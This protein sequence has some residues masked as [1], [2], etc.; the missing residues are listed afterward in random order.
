[1]ALDQALEALSLGGRGHIDQLALGEDVALELLAD[2]QAVVAPDL[3]DV[4]VGIGAGLL[5]LAQQRLGDLPL[6]DR[7]K[8]QPDRRV[9][10]L[11]DGP[12]PEDAAGPHLEHGHGRDGA[13]GVEDL[14]HAELAGEESFRHG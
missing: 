9:A 8:G 11:L 2:L 6:G 13:V 14:R 3:G 4:P 1:M 12:Q 10:V 5:E 7:R